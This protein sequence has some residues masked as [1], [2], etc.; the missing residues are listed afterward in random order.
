V[1]HCRRSE[2]DAPAFSRHAP[3]TRVREVA[4]IFAYFAAAI[5]L[6]ALLAPPL[7][8]MA[9]SEVIERWALSTSLLQIV[10]TGGETVETGG[11]VY[12]GPLTFL[13][14]DFQKFFNRAVLIAA[15]V[16]LWPVVRWLKV[17]TKHDLG[18]D[19][20]PR[21]WSHL[22]RGFGIAALL[23][24]AMAGAY[25]LFDIYDLKRATAEQPLPWGH[26]PR[27]ALTAAVV[28]VLEEVLFRGAILGL[29]LRA[30][31]SY[32]ALLWTSAIFA[33]LHFLKP[34]DDVTMEHV[35]W[36]SGFQL[37]PH[38]FHQFAEP[39]MLLAGFTTL[40]VLGW[41][42]GYARLRTRSLWMSI[43]LHAGVVFVKMSFSKFTKRQEEFLPWIGPELQIGL[44]PVA[45]LLV[46]LF[47]VWRRM[48]HEDLLPAPA[49][50]H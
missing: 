41:L 24:A 17:G 26:L 14:A 48:E 9:R 19:A 21:R 28:A 27:I 38:T 36:L 15:I 22:A 3:E 40:F 8:W 42:L 16:L 13:R 50:R 10:P 35:T 37:L 31:R 5:V 46:A 20:D 25:L 18:L 44:V 7:Y 33:I 43:G 34:D 29:F 49:P 4:K 45:V 47:L 2:L 23:V 32:A 12:K 6:G 11:A 1:S 30:M 39:V